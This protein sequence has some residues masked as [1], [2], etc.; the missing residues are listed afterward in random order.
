MAQ[1]GHTAAMPERHVVA[2]GGGGFLMEPSR[3]LDDYVLDL[4]GKSEPSVCF[5]ATASGDAAADIEIAAG[6]RHADLRKRQTKSLKFSRIDDDL[7]LLDE[8]ANAGD[9]GNTFGLGELISDGPVLEGAQFGQSHLRAAQ[10][11]LIGPADAG[12]IRTQ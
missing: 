3:L 10:D 8:A 4:C 5:L 1:V 12:R 7:I 9:L 6:N 11:V 2:M